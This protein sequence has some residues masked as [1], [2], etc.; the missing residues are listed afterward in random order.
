[1]TIKVFCLLTSAAEEK[2]KL[3]KEVTIRDHSELDEVGKD[4]VCAAVSAV[5]NGGINFFHQYFPDQGTIEVSESAALV[6]VRVTDLSDPNFQLSLNMMLYQ[7][8]NIAK[9]YPE[10][11]LLKYEEDT[12]FFHSN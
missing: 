1:M 10:N 7:L 11:L 3:I 6:V 4:I 2:A 5:V 9:F 8:Q 12:S